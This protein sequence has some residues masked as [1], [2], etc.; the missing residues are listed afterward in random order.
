MRGNCRQLV[1]ELELSAQQLARIAKKCP[2]LLRTV[3]SG[4]CICTC[5]LLHVECTHRLPGR[6]WGSVAG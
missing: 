2:Y 3:S 6:A 4:S 5:P 1:Q